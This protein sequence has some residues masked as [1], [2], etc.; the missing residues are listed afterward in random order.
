MNIEL[1]IRGS[2]ES[3][4]LEPGDRVIVSL[5]DHVRVPDFGELSKK[6]RDA[7]PDNEVILLAP[8]IRITRE[9]HE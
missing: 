7:F 1:T 4:H 5:E 6:F 3:L 9:T 2:V 8:G